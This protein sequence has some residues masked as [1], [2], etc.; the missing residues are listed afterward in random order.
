MIHYLSG[1]WKRDS[2]HQASLGSY[3]LFA[4]NL[5]WQTIAFADTHLHLVAVGNFIPEY[6]V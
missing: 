1:G 5:R 6:I 4:S 3:R 2:G